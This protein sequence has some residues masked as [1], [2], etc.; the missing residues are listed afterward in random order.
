[1]YRRSFVAGIMLVMMF[2]LFGCTTGVKKDAGLTDFEA[3]NIPLNVVGVGKEKAIMLTWSSNSEADLVGY[4]IYRSNNSGGPFTLIATVGKMAAPTYLDNDNQNGLVNDQ[5]YY[6]KLSAFDTQGKESDLARTNAIQARA[7]LPVEERPPRVVNIKVRA[8]QQNVYIAWDKV[9]GARI[10]GYNIYRGLSTSAGGVQWISSVPQDTPGYVDTSV[11]RTSAE[12]YTYVIRSF[13]EQY[14]ESENSDPV[15]VTLRS[16]DDTI[17]QAP[18]D[19]SVSNDTDPVIAWHK[20]MFNQNG[21]PIFE[22]NNP[23]LDLDAY[24]VFRANQNDRLFSLVGIVED[25][26]SANLTQTFKDVNGTPYNLYAVRAIDRNG[27]VSDLSSIVTQSADADIPEIPAGVLA[28]SSTSTEAGIKL[29][30]NAAKNAVSYNIYFST[31]ADGG[32]TKYVTGQPQW[33]ETSAYVI[34]TYPSNFMQNPEK[35]GQKLE[36]GI[37]YFFKISSVSSSGKE[38]DLSNYVKAYPGGMWV[39]LLEGENTLW[40]FLERGTAGTIDGSYLVYNSRDYKHIDYYSGSG[41]A[42]LLADTV[43]TPGNGDG[44]Q[45]GNTGLFSTLYHKLPSPTSGSYR[46]N[47]YAYIFPH[48]SCGNWRVQ[49]RENGVLTTSLLEKD[50]SGYSSINRGRT[51]VALGQIILNQ[52]VE[53]VAIEMTAINAGA[54]G[55]ANMFFDALAFVR[56]P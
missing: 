14:T 50:I 30:W 16:G 27:M 29:A 25:N 52:G 51:Q 35:K 34:N 21:T 9:T 38:S 4:R 56:A 24:L 31:V 43:G 1:R 3:P 46:Y 26:G 10:K 7:G 54:G 5:Y 28:W 18:Y 40:E 44:Y 47:V 32:Y 37:P 48:T 12:Q 45:F 22:G 41:V 11:I 20:P 55:G 36:F 42:L 17:P 6:Y 15:Q 13:N 49:I 19:L 23:T 2:T 53:G 33:T 8:S 39:G